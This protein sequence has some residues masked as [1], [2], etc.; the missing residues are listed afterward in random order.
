MCFAFLSK[1]RINTLVTD[2]FGRGGGALPERR[3][4]LFIETRGL[5]VTCVP[6]GPEASSSSSR[7]NLMVFSSKHQKLKIFILLKTFCY[8][9]A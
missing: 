9:I 4:I 2:T 8:A 6:G 3:G 7:P 5:R 1:E